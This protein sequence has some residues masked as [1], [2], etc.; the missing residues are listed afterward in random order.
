VRSRRRR[1]VYAA[2]AALVVAAA[3]AAAALL[4]L[5]GGDAPGQ[6]GPPAGNEITAAAPWRLFVTNT[7]GDNCMVTVTNTDTGDRKDFQNISG[8]QQFQMQATGT[9]RWEADDP[10]CLVVKH[11]GPRTATLPFSE[12]AGTPG[13]PRR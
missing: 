13:C 12:Y 2:A 7:T 3:G 8:E 11:S 5:D 4:I 9:F 10:G 6:A 1:L